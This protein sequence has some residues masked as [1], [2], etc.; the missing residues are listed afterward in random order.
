MA[1]QA[2]L[3][4]DIPQLLVCSRNRLGAESRHLCVVGEEVAL[5]GKGD[6]DLAGAGHFSTFLR[7]TTCDRC[8]A[9]AEAMGPHPEQ[10]DG[11][12]F[13]IKPLHAPRGGERSA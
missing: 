3:G 7:W 13:R 9:K 5:C 6:Q 10:A 8:R 1:A 12:G 11:A 4:L 2:R